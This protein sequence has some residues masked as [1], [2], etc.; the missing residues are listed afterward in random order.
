MKP[1]EQIMLHPDGLLRFRWARGRGGEE[2][3]RPRPYG[4]T[5]WGWGMDADKAARDLDPQPLIDLIQVTQVVI[6]VEACLQIGVG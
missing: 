5:G 2:A 1:V 6:G 3:R 4:V